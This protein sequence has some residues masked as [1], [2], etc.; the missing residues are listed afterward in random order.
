MDG[1][2]VCPSTH[3]LA[4]LECGSPKEW[5]TCGT[6]EHTE[7]DTVAGTRTNGTIAWKRAIGRGGGGRGGA[8]A[9]SG[10]GR[11]GGRW[12]G[13]R[14]RRQIII[15]GGHNLAVE[16]WGVGDYWLLFGTAWITI[17]WLFWKKNWRKNSIAFTLHSQCKNWLWIWQKRMAHKK[18]ASK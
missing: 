15:G 4:L 13:W 2:I 11:D 8:V 3:V 5:S 17:C 7:I 6:G 12:E 16:H 1:T 18:N 10:D 9:I 14:G